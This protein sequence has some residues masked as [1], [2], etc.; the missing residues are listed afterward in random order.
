MDW[1]WQSVR[2]HEGRTSSMPKLTEESVR[3]AADGILQEDDGEDTGVV[4]S[5][6]WMAVRYCQ[7]YIACKGFA[8]RNFQVDSECR[9][10]IISFDNHR[11]NA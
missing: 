10:R 3:R 8:E 2:M 1:V 7:K 6:T 5:W 4:V 11:F 9:E